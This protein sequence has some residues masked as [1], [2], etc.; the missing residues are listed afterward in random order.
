[1]E[2]NGETYKNIP[3]RWIWTIA[4]AVIIFLVMFLPGIWE[5]KQREEE[6]KYL[7][8]LQT[9]QQMAEAKNTRKKT[10]QQQ[11]RNEE[12]DNPTTSLTNMEQEKNTERKETIIR[13]LIS[14]DGTEQYLHSDVRISCPASYLVKGDITVQQEAGT[15]LC[16]SERMQPGQTVIVDQV[17]LES[18]LKGVVPSEM[19]ADAPEEALCAQAVC[20][21][22]Y[23]V[24]QIRE[25]RM[26]EWDA[27]VD[28]TVS[29][30]VYNNISE[31]AAS[32]QAV[33]AT[34]GMI[35]LSDGKP[36]EAYFFSTSWGCTD[37][38]EVWNA[39]KSASYLRSIAVSHKAVETMV[40]GI[41]QPEMTEQSFRERILQRDA[42]DYEKEDVWYRWKVCIPWE[43]LKE[44][45]ERKWPQLGAFTGLSI[46]G[47]NPG[48]G[49]K[50][51]E[52]QGENQNATLENEYVIR[53]FLSIKG[54][55]VSRN[56]GSVCDTMELLPSACFIVDFRK[57]QG[58][59]T[60]VFTGGGYGHGVGM[61]QNGAKHLAEN[62]LGWRDILQIF[63][64]NITIENLQEY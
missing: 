64:Q 50:T 8:K 38:D 22:T 42:G 58:T 33:D 28:D 7:E 45:S 62:G 46:Q 47:R 31:Q 60:F 18:Y 2:K 53:K 59:G 3:W 24:R 48:G 55:S 14:V 57:E 23:A 27:D 26:K 63:Y 56:D 1:M 49:V 11:K 5:G 43:M 29:C 4:G 19:P 13:V 10:E 35:I 25:E 36:I 9:E 51:L 16:L 20:A 54:L 15:E 52:I 6:K 30:Q 34:R 21:R 44:R 40:N 61:S 17:D 37:T 39:K 12:I 32:S 41:L